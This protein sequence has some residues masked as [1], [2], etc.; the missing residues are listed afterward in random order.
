MVPSELVRRDQPEVAESHEFGLLHGLYD[1]I[2]FDGGH[3]FPVVTNDDVEDWIEQN[4]YWESESSPERWFYPSSRKVQTKMLQGFEG[5]V[6]LDV[7]GGARPAFL[8][9]PPVT[10]RIDLFELPS[11]SLHE[12]RRFARMAIET[13]AFLYD[14]RCQFADWQLDS[15]VPVPRRPNK[16][17]LRPE[18]LTSILNQVLDRA[19]FLSDDQLTA[20]LNVLHLRNKLTSYDWYWERF[21]WAYICVDGCWRVLAGARPTEWAGTGE[22]TH[23]NGNYT[24]H[25]Q[26]LNRLCDC[27]G[28]DRS[29]SEDQDLLDLAVSL[30]NN[31]IHEFSWEGSTPGMGSS[32]DGFMADFGLRRFLDR[33]L[34][35]L[36]GVDCGFRMFGGWAGVRSP[37]PLK[38]A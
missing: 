9:P 30:R 31:V 11:P 38:L 35:H 36:L 12:D 14:C 8:S 21:V 6:M 24:P 2:A 13:L 34:F 32:G 17:W 3:I 10:H 29:H 16:F 1:T 18:H 19:L 22:V 7:K 37:P 26:R 20:T 27:L 15:R 33:L 28:I 5:E 4:G 23:S 25:A